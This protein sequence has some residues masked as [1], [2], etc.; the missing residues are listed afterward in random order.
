MV[1]P[2]HHQLWTLQRPNFSN[3][4]NV[5][6]N[7]KSIFLMRNALYWYKLCCEHFNVLGENLS[8]EMM[9]STFSDY[10]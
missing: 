10:E 8:K 4:N 9:C 7:K 3:C 5:T 1:Q 6:T 2:A